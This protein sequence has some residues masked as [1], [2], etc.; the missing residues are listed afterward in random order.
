MNGETLAG[1]IE[2]NTTWLAKNLF[3]Q[4]ET[5]ST[6]EDIKR[7][8][9]EGA[10][11]GTL[12]VA[13]M[14][15][16]GKGRRGR[17][18]ASPKGESVYMSLLL[19]PECMPDQASALTLVMALAVL[20]AIEEL[21]PGK[22]GIKWPNDIVMNSRKV[23]GILTEMSLEK[24][25]IG[26]VVVGVG[27]NANQLFFEE[28]ISATATSIARELGR[29]IE[30]ESLIGRVLYYFEQEYAEYEKTWDLTGLV[31]KYNT[32]LLNK[33]RQVRVLDPKGEYEGTALG[34]NTKG[35]LLVRKKS[36]DL[37]EVYAGEVSVRGIYGYV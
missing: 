18:W 24:N 1:Q 4:E 21:A 15:T 17:T 6:N 36:G 8:A 26:Y 32:Y 27:I 35:E 14:Q 16:A 30:R 3:F 9:R 25:A 19:R 29:K 37:V 13:D 28:E 7:L 10:M 34:I 23:C 31:E 22:S 33:D 12:A 2:K 20:E 11:H 5:D